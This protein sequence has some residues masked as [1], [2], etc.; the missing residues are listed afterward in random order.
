V[1]RCG[2]STFI[3][4][5][6]GG[7]PLVDD[8]LRITENIAN[9]GEWTTTVFGHRQLVQHGTCAFGVVST[10]D[11]DGLNFRVWNEDIISIIHDSVNKF[12]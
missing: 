8:C 4:Q 10:G 12:Q 1:N 11:G 5:S 6:S 9:D 7:S 2:D 3:N